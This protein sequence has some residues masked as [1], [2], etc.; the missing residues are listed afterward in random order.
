MI[1]HNIRLLYGGMAFRKR[2]L[3]NIALLQFN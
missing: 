2:I 3:Y 1:R